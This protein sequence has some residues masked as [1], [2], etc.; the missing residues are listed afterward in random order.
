MEDVLRYH[1]V[2]STAVAYRSFSM[3]SISCMPRY[4]SSCLSPLLRAGWGSGCMFFVVNPSSKIKSVQSKALADY[5]SDPEL[6]EIKG[7]PGASSSRKTVVM[8]CLK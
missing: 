2:I 6:A 7:I 8:E 5:L 3:W 1:E 4:A